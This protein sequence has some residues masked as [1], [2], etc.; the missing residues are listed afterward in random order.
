M[1][2]CVIR[3]N[4]LNCLTDYI[5][6][7]NYTDMRQLF[8][9]KSDQTR[10][11]RSVF[12]YWKIYIPINNWPDLTSHLVGRGLPGLGI[13]NLPIRQGHLDGSA[14]VRSSLCHQGF[15]FGFQLGVQAETLVDVLGWRQQLKSHNL[16]YFILHKYLNTQ[17]HLFRSG[18][19]H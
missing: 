6:N 14:I 12:I 13:Y 17:V 5:Q 11:T 7:V 19:S 8:V 10:W 3:S 9:Y 15:V 1:Q 16:K 2:I 4:M 18:H